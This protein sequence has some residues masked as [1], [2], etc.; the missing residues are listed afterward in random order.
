M[1]F[2][3]LENA[4]E[5]ALFNSRW[6]MAP[7]FIGLIV[8]LIVLLFK[9]VVILYEFIMH[10]WAAGESD[11]ILGVLSLIDMALTGNLILIIVFAGYENFV[12]RIDASSHPDWP[13]WIVEIDF[14]G[15]KQ[16]VLTSIVAIAA[17]RVLKAFMS[18][19]TAGDTIKLAWLVGILLV[20]VVSTI[21]IVW[22]DRLSKLDDRRS[23]G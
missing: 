9:F 15:L 7:F 17:I 4:L 3:R 6:L 13:E 21:L 10:A 22:S 5:N 12:S 8:S 1:Q 11:I 18:L 19:D 16:K 2:K 14:T 23:S 20:F